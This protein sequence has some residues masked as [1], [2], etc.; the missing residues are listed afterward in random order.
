M[1]SSYYIIYYL[2]VE[3]K[4]WKKLPRQKNVV[5]LKTNKM[6][7]IELSLNFVLYNV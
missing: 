7:K 6:E 4:N 3:P 5:L 2:G 1:Q